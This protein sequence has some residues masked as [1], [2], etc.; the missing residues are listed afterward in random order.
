MACRRPLKLEYQARVS[1]RYRPSI[2]LGEN[3]RKSLGLAGCPVLRTAADIARTF[4]DLTFLEREVMVSGTLDCKCRLITWSLLGVGDS[5]FVSLRTG[6]V[7]HDAIRHRTSGVFL[8]HNH[9]SGDPTPSRQ[10]RKLTR[11]IARAG[12]LLGYPLVDHVVVA[13]RGYVTLVTAEFIRKHRQ[14][15]KLQ[16]SIAVASP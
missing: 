3:V 13:R 12:L 4:N 11:D 14:T 8:V 15:L 6:E 10:D 1:T 2:P 16:N 5:S 7:F 9:P